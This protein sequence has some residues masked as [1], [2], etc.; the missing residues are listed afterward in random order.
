VKIDRSVIKS[1]D[2]RGTYPDQLD[3]AFAYLLG[4]AL[5][6]VVS[7]QRVAVGHDARLSS[8]PLYAALATGFEQAGSNVVGLGLCPTELVYYVLG[9][10]EDFELGVMVTA[11]HNPPEYNGF[12]VVGAGARPVT[13]ETGLGAACGA[14]EQMRAA[15][16]EQPQPPRETVHVDSDYLDFALELLGEPPVEDL[17]VVVDAGNGL[18]GLLWESLAA[19]LGLEPVRLNFQPDGRFPAHPPDPT[20]EV[21]LVPLVRRVRA[22]A[23]DIGFA[24]DGDAD[25][26]VMVLADG[27]IV[28]GSETTA[29]IA[30]RTLKEEPGCAFGMGQ[31]VSRK[32]LDYFRGLGLEPTF[33]PVGH[34]K[35]KSVL[36]SHPDMAFAGESAGHYYYRDFFSCDSALLTTLHVLHLL[37]EGELA[38]L[39][40]AL[41]GP[42]HSPVRQPTIEFGDQD[43]ALEVCRRVALAAVDEWPEPVEITCEK[44]GAVMRHCAPDRIREGLSARVD[45]A[46]RWF[47]VRPSGTEPIARLT[48]EARSPEE[49][50][51][52]RQRLLGLFENLR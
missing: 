28:D 41:P 24:Y 38:E 46:D 45:Y 39:I 50:E 12:K 33:V 2:I 47:C 17:S 49:L 43:H 16:P 18:G 25:R 14:M 31:T 34:A 51:E 52:M 26:V 10:R 29:C 15:L 27:H 48:L 4:K 36:R 3:E 19:R 21:N 9:A 6:G 20:D 1:Y 44:E 8:P 35:I 11:S 30:H 32:A 5:P 7:A 23:A 22:E 37:A 13:G 42:W 40:G